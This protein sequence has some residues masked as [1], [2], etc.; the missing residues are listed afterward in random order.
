MKTDCQ[1]SGEETGPKEEDL[2][3]NQE[4]EKGSA[5]MK[6]LTTLMSVEKTGDDELVD[7]RV[8]SI[9]IC[10][11]GNQPGS[12]GEGEELGERDDHRWISTITLILS[13]PAPPQHN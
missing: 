3:T 4:K 5:C 12:W 1:N 10:K 2:A 9:F 11:T 13:T 7:M 6:T 8:G